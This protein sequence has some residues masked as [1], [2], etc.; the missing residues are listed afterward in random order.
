MN[1]DPSGAGA[2]SDAA[3]CAFRAAAGHV[4]HLP[5]SDVRC[6]EWP[7]LII[8]ALDPEISGRDV[9]LHGVTG[10]IGDFGMQD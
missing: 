5:A 4:N 8:A 2:H 9:T 6:Q 1:I 7:G 3:D 10:I